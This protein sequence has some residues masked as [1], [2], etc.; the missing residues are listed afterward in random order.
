[1]SRSYK[2]PIWTEGAGTERRQIMKRLANKKIRR[3]DIADGSDYKKH[4]S[5]WAICDW[6]VPYDNPEA[7]N[8]YKGI[9]K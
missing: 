1:M 6:K 5:S 4:F 3:E 8:F 9:S 7:E 2:T